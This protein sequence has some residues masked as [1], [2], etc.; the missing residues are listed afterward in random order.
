VIPTTAVVMRGAKRAI[1]NDGGRDSGREW[2]HS[3]EG[4]RNA[5]GE[6]LDSDGSGGDSEPGGRDFG[7][8]SA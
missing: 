8:R 5:S 4:V 1:P 6:A 2:H 7:S 3:D